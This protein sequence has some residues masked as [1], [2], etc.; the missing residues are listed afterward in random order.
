MNHRMSCA[1]LSCV[2]ALTSSAALA[3]KPAA[4][5]PNQG[6][7]KIDGVESTDMVVTKQYNLSPGLLTLAHA[8]E[9]HVSFSISFP[10]GVKAGR[11]V[12]AKETSG[13]ANS[14]SING[15]VGEKIVGIGD[16]YHVDA[17]IKK[18]GAV[19]DVAFTG[20]LMNADKKLIPVEGEF[21]VSK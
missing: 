1:L 17:T 5:K 8:D 11:Y 6:H 19:F 12:F 20:Q 15:T 14:W 18:V 3:D 7:V 21:T 4:L 10:K 9:P 16:G 2:M 13:K